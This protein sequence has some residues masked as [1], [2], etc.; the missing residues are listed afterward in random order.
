MIV[1][2]SQVGHSQQGILTEESGIQ[3]GKTALVFSES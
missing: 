1:F 2:L 3:H